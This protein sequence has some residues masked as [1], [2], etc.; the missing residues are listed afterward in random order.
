MFSK[1]HLSLDQKS[2]LV[3][4]QWSYI[5]KDFFYFYIFLVFYLFYVDSKKKLLTS[6]CHH[7]FV[8][9]ANF[10]IFDLNLVGE[11]L[12]LGNHIS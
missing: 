7:D 4:I 1:S 12:G 8:S 6:R 5:L 3:T 10:T 2:Y 9:N 11:K